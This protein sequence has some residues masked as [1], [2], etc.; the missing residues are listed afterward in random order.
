MLLEDVWRSEYILCKS[1]APSIILIPRNQFRA[2][3]FTASTLTHRDID[4]APNIFIFL[5]FVLVIVS[6][7]SILDGVCLLCGT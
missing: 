3:A 1:F 4:L 6:S 2:S 5:K 7:L